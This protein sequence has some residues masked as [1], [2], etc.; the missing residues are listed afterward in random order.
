MLET[1]I[2]MSLLIFHLVLVLMLRLG[3]FTD[4]TI[5]HMILVHERTILPLDALVAAHVLI[6]VTVS[7]IGPVFSCWRVLHSL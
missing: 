7:H 5:A 4:L 1:H 3:S 6:M 2:M